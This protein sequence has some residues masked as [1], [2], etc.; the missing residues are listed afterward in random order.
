[1]VGKTILPIRKHQTI[2]AKGYMERLLTLEHE[3]AKDQSAAGRASHL[4]ITARKA[5][6]PQIHTD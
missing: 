1:V 2:L 6:Q 4:Q 3:L 5:A